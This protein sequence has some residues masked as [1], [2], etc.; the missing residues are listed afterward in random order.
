MG[1][2]YQNVGVSYIQMAARICLPRTLSS[3]HS[4]QK[5]VLRPNI[6]S[7]SQRS[8]VASTSTSDPTQYLYNIPGLKAKIIDGKKIAST[9]K[10]EITDE[11]IEVLASHTLPVTSV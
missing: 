6:I 2:R 9:V 11:V 7:K 1:M 10:T 5:I 8:R 3:I 4:V